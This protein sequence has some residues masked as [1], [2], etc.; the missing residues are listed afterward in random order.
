M[1]DILGAAHI[2]VRLGASLLCRS[3]GL[4][5]LLFLFMSV[6]TYMITVW[7]AYLCP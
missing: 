1:D 3:T 2:G 7:F 6:E 4:D 5:C